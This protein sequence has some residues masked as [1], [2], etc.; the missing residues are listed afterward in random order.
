M[1]EAVA[2]CSAEL[3][4]KRMQELSISALKEQAPLFVANV[5]EN[6]PS[7]HRTICFIAMLLRDRG[8]TDTADQ[9]FRHV[10]RSNPHDVVALYES[11]VMDAMLGRQ[12]D[13]LL[14]L[15][16][17]ITRQRSDIRALQFAARMAAR[18]GDFES[19]KRYIRAADEVEP[20]NADTALVRELAD[21]MSVVPAGAAERLARSFERDRNYVSADLIA[22]WAQ[23]HL[24][25]RQGFSLVRLGDG[26]GVFCRIS[27][28]DENR[29]PVLYDYAR[30][31]RAHVWFG[32]EIDIAT[33]GFNEVAF[34]V[35]NVVQHASVVG[36]PYWSW[37]VH[38]FKFCSASGIT[39]L[40]NAL[41]LAS[42]PSVN[43]GQSW[44]TQLVHFDM[45]QC[46]AL[47]RLIR[48]QKRIHL[49]TCLPEAGD[50]LRR[51]FGLEE[52][53]IHRVPGEKAHALQLGIGAMIGHH[54]P[55][56]FQELINELSADQRGELFLVAAGLLGKF[57]CRRIHE[58]GGVALDVGSV[59]DQWM[60]KPTRPNV[61]IRNALQSTPDE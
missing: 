14:S 42:L 13:A 35:R 10:L 30:R 48:S 12:A 5:L 32:G 4:L 9:L 50:R 59:V 41:R 29:F 7:N 11:A 54:F 23:V 49:I 44:T 36:L 47:E 55:G 34:G 20:G 21:F 25:R 22:G 58:S 33:S 26:E 28:D 38:E 51:H 60:G 40:V 45:L 2:L 18:I 39:G 24:E 17:I 31:N 53:V 15:E 52:V 16:R 27:T 19:S 1:V 57:Y 56:R 43:R 46:G 61:D 37:V 8:S 6:D 3:I